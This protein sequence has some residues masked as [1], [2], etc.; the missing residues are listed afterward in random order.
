[1]R[2]GILGAG[3]I[4]EKMAETILGLK[5]KDVENYAIASRS[6]DKANAYKE[7]WG[8]SR[9]YGSY[10][11]LMKERRALA[12]AAAIDSNIAERFFDYTHSALARAQH[13]MQQHPKYSDPYYWAGF[14]V[15]D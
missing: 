15:V 8:F 1:M 13:R 9:A 4:A 6:T 12:K 2:V 5:D 14:V 10:E 11:E 3:G 7:K